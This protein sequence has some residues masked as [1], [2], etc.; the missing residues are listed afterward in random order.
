MCMPSKCS[1]CQK[2]TWWGCGSH[3][4][5]VMDQVPESERCACTPK[6]NA[7]GKEYPPKGAGPA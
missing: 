1:N 7:D 2:K 5:S 6:V 4:P 3:I